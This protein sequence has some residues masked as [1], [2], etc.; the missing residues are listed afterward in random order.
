MCTQEAL[1]VTELRFP[2]H[3]SFSQAFDKA[4]AEHSEQL[5]SGRVVTINLPS[6]GYTRR[7]IAT[8]EAH[9]PAS[10]WIDKRCDP[11][12]FSARI[13]AAAKSLHEQRYFGL[14]E[15]AHED[16]VATIRRLVPESGRDG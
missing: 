7:A 1:K 3:S 16:G 12:R 15:L 13:R 14:F 6:G 5:L 11:T 8:I 2:E 9:N 4:I 10:F